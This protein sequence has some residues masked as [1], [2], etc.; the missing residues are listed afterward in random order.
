LRLFA[1]VA[2]RLLLLIPVLFGISVVTFLLLR[3]VPGDP[4]R[5][6][7]PQTATD[8]DLARIRERYGLDRSLIEQYWIYLNKLLH[9]DFGRSFQTG[10]PVTHEMF[11][12]LGPTIELVTAALS[13]ALL[14]G[15]TLGV[16]SALRVNRPSDHVIRVG[17]L[18]ATAIPEFWL[19]LLLILVFYYELGVV[20]APTGRYGPDFAFPDVT[21]IDLIDAALAGNAAAFGSVLSHLLLPVA[22]LAAVTSAPIIRTV[23]ASALHALASE[24]YRCGEAHGLPRRTLVRHY[25]LRESLAGVPTLAALIYGNLL[26]GAVLIEFIFGWQGFGQWALQALQVRDYPVI[27][28]FVLVSATVYVVVFLIADVIHAVLDPRVKL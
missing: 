21:R 10:A 3:V 6:L 15:I 8:A 23:R 22:A 24:S 2:K 4:L 18:A 9:G 25:V 17:S 27:Q 11:E 1:Y 13:V 5:S 20:A 7:L 14:T 19:A 12:R 28:A 16:V 26:G